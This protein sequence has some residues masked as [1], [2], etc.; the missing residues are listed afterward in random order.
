[1]LAHSEVSP[2][3]YAIPKWQTERH[4]RH[5]RWARDAPVL[6]VAADSRARDRDFAEIILFDGR[7]REWRRITVDA[8][9][10]EELGYGSALGELGAQL[11]AD[12]SPD[13]KSVVTVVSG[14]TDQ[15]PF[16]LS[17]IPVESG[18]KPTRLR[19]DLGAAP[20][21]AWS[22]DGSSLVVAGAVK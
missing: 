15:D 6:L 11:W 21:F 3:R 12:V 14:V 19:A 18:S 20:V 16:L 8:T 9:V 5:L 13:G 4:V 1:N 17:S 10:A 7:H 2:L 22:R